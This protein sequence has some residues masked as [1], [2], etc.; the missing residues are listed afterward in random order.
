MEYALIAVISF[1]AGA[2]VALLYGKAMV[3]DAKAEVTRAV[4]G[5]ETRVRGDL[6]AMAAKLA[7]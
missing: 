3:A 5:F 4:D 2:V 6:S 7:K 1:G